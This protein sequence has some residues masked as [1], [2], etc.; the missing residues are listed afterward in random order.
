METGAAGCFM[1]SSSSLNIWVL[2]CIVLRFR[3]RLSAK[4]FDGSGS[5]TGQYR[6]DI[7]PSEACCLFGG[8]TL[9]AGGSWTDTQGPWWNVPG[10]RQWR[11]AS[12]WGDRRVAHLD[13]MSQ[14]IEQPNEMVALSQANFAVVLGLPYVWLLKW[15]LHLKRSINQTLHTW[16]FRVAI[17]V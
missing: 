16:H 13:K 7:T 11:L 5:A 14:G 9:A 3:C 10:L 12:C 17:K 4:A 2:L 15:Q 6:F 1:F 8:D